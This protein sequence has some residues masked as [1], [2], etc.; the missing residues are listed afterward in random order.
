MEYNLLL[1]PVKIIDQM[2]SLSQINQK[3]VFFSSELSR[4]YIIDRKFILLLFSVYVSG[5]LNPKEKM[6]VVVWIHG[7][8]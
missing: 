4:Y 1:G 2:R 7:G 3:T 6:P 8:G 5:T